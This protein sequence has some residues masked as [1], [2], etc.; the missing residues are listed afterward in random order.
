V[1]VVNS[2]WANGIMNRPDMSVAWINQCYTKGINPNFRTVSIEHEGLTGQ[3]FTN[4]QFQATLALHKWLT[5]TFN[6]PV[7]RVH[8]VGHYMIDS[9]NRPYCPGGG[10]PWGRLLDELK[11]NTTSLPADPN[12]HFFPETGVYVNNDY[13]F[14]DYWNK[15]GGLA[16]LSATRSA[17][18]VT[19]R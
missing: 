17:Q 6:I 14:L 7:D 8:L 18:P 11:G 5:R 4:A 16:G 2:A 9:V 3:A 13:G 15:N 10:F 19:T 12:V 1:K